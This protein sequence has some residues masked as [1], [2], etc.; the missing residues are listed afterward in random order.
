MCASL[1]RRVLIRFGEFLQTFLTEFPQFLYLQ[2]GF[3]FSFTLRIFPLFI[4]PHSQSSFKR[5]QIAKV[6]TWNRNQVMFTWWMYF[7]WEVYDWL[8]LQTD[9]IFSQNILKYINA[10]IG[11][12]LPRCSLQFHFKLWNS[13][14]KISCSI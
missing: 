7:Q 1:Q 4:F 9:V 11:I 12:T 8:L 3:F 6:S 13:T 14:V 5:R 2:P 10:K